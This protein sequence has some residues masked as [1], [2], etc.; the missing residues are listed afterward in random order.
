MKPVK[1]IRVT[2]VCLMLCVGIATGGCLI[3]AYAAELQ[4]LPVQQINT[5]LD[6]AVQQGIAGV[7]LG[8]GTPEGIWLTSAG[9][10]D[11]DSGEQM[12]PY[13]QIRLASITK[14]FT[15]SLVWCLIEKGVLRQTDTI[16]RWLP[17][18]L[19]PGEKIITIG[20]LLNHTSGLYDH[21]DGEFFK[22]LEANP[23]HAWTN[24]Q[25][26]RLARKHP[27]QSVPGT[28][29]AYCNTGYFILGMI[30]EAA[31]GKK[32]ETLL[33][34][35]VFS[36]VGMSRT[37]VSRGGRLGSPCTGGYC[38]LDGEGLVSTLNWSFS[39][40]WTAGAGVSTALDMLI[41][42][43][44]LSTCKILTPETTARMWTVSPPSKMGYG[45]LVQTDSAGNRMISHSGKNPGTETNWIF[46]PDSGR[47]L[48]IGF[49]LDDLRSNPEIQDVSIFLDL[50]TGILQALGW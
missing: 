32:V 37:S 22:I 41:W 33:D 7:V 2:L 17:P 46:Y 38:Y 9:K 1:Q 49:N 14:T 29:F 6:S 44:A 13:D 28:E 25:V 30:I 23:T 48:F 16:S 11:L 45:F 34:Q 31:T 24:N 8:I 21:E 40:D 36:K 10:A 42:A 20:M 26:L 39:W 4:S 18:G 12:S 5:L 3:E 35:I 50:Q 19:V 27:L 43:N 15:A 47:A